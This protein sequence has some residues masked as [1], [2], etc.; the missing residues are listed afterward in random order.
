M[1]ESRTQKQAAIE[2]VVRHF[3]ASWEMDEE[4]SPNAYVT[5]AGK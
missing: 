3:S 2:A 5:I 4:G 1:R